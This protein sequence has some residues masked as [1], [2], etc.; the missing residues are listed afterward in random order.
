MNAYIIYVITSLSLLCNVDK[1]GWPGEVW[2]DKK[3]I[4]LAT[5]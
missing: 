4:V 3:D 1:T 5:H 2:P